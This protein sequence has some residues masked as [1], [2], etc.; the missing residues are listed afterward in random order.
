MVSVSEPF[1]VKHFSWTICRWKFCLWT[2][3]R[4]TV[5]CMLLILSYFNLCD[6]FL[7]GQVPKTAIKTPLTRIG[8]IPKKLHEGHLG[9][10]FDPQKE[11]VT[12][13]ELLRIFQPNFTDISQIWSGIWKFMTKFFFKMAT[14]MAAPI[15]N[16]MYL[17]LL[18][19]TKTNTVSI[20]MKWRS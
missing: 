9:V 11:I 19:D 12:T 10:F 17:S 6:L 1:V 2:F 7:L 20:H 14:N 3:C 8:H 18:S 15:L 5:P 4:G 16:R 13:S